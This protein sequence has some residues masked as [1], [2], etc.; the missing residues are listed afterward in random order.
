MSLQ[1]LNLPPKFRLNPQMLIL[2][3][4]CFAMPLIIHTCFESVCF[5]KHKDLL[6]M[7]HLL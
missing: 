6:P 3:L 7:N 2:T 4:K 5:L 1:A